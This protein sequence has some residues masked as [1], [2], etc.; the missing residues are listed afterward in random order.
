MKPPASISV[1]HYESSVSS[2]LE[3]EAT[4]R[5]ITIGNRVSDISPA[6]TLM[7]NGE[8]TGWVFLYY[9]LHRVCVCFPLGP[10]PDL[11]RQRVQYGCRRRSGYSQ[12]AGWGQ[13]SAAVT[14]I[15]KQMRQVLKRGGYKPAAASN[16]L[17]CRGFFM[18]NKSDLVLYNPWNPN[19][20][21]HS[22][23]AVGSSGGP[24]KYSGFLETSVALTVK[25]A[26]F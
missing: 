25:Y 12:D 11:S 15:T 18:K 14:I 24:C 10:L 7:L 8:K 21:R 6:Q 1:S 2:Q 3:A 9:I 16:S 4:H 20:L 23:H 22:V 13:F 17:T 26:E 5:A 19:Q